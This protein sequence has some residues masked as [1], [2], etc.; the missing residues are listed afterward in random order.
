[1]TEASLGHD[2][3]LTRSPTTAAHP[4]TPPRS[5]GRVLGIFDA[6]ARNPSG[7]KLIELAQWLGAP[8]SSL[9]N[10]LRPMVVDGY[11]TLE[12]LHYRLG[13]AAFRL[14]ASI[15]SGW[16]YSDALHPFV[17]ELAQSTRESVHLGVMDPSGQSIVYVDTIDCARPIRYSTPVGC[18]R[19]LH[20]TAG[21]R[22]PLAFAEPTSAASYLQD[23]K[24]LNPARWTPEA[25]R[26]LRDWLIDI[27]TTH[28]SMNLQEAASE[29]GSIAAPIF[30]LSDDCIAAIAVSAPESELKLRLGELQGHLQSVAKRASASTG[31]LTRGHTEPQATAPFKGG[32]TD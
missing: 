32:K 21:G 4:L 27:R 14:S 29:F 22:V 12:N 3:Q 8:T 16:N 20:S 30:G 6:L 18:T 28:C 15:M 19:P 13:P 24:S 17:V 11:L 9:L 7:M 10:L 1:M 25:R 23:L 31:L 26:W 5:L 2:A